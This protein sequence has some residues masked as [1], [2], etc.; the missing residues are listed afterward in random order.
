[1]KRTCLGLLLCLIAAASAKPLVA[2]GA[3]LDA[4][5]VILRVDASGRIFENR[6]RG[7][8]RVSHKILERD[9]QGGCK[10]DG[11]VSSVTVDADPTVKH[12]TVQQLL[13]WIRSEAPAGIP[14]T[15]QAGHAGR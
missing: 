5:P 4:C 1:M 12:M 7:M 11:P 13:D 14:V 15:L 3:R 6:M 10:D 8:Y 9:L 2:Q